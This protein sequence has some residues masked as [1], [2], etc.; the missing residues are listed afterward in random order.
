MFHG[1]CHRKGER[2]GKKREEKYAD[3]YLNVKRDSK[4]TVKF[5]EV[6]P[7]CVFSVK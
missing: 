2:Q 4:H 7:G 5:T 3:E 1:C 6:C